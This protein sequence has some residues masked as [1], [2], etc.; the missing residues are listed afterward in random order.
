MNN[1]PFVPIIIPFYNTPEKAFQR[2]IDSLINQTNQDFEAIVINDGSQEQ[3][4]ESLERIVEKDSRIRLLNKKNEG[5]AIAR[6][7]GIAEAQGDYIMF[8]DSDDAL[9]EFCLEEAVDAIEIS[10]ADIAFGGVRRVVEEEIDALHPIKINKPQRIDINTNDER[11]SF[12]SHLIG[13][14]NPR[15]EL[16]NGYLADGPV[17]RLLKKSIAKEALFSEESIWNDDTIWNAKM[18]VRCNSV[19][20]IDDLWYKYLIYSNSKTRKFRPNCQYE[21]DYR[22]KQEIDLFKKLWPNCMEGIYNR[23]FNDIVILCR[24]YLFNPQ[25]NKSNKEKYRVY[26][27]CIHTPAYREALKGLNLRKERRLIN[28]IAKEVMRFTAY[29]GPNIVSYLI[30]KLFYYRR[31]NTL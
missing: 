16:T 24:T 17:A 26:K 23:V 21:F 29:Y 14:T 10:H 25:N 18:L 19:C 9:T 2:C 15:F 6:N 22:T 31:K 5:S 12:M 3:Y 20:I 30:L 8:L 27:E 13:D 11:D 7:V 4:Q 28:R 1:K